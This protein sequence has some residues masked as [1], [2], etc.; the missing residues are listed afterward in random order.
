MGDQQDGEA[1]LP[2]EVGEELEDLRLQ[3]DVERRGRLVGEQQLRPAG[4]RHGDHRPLAL[5]AGEL[6]GVVAEPPSGVGDRHPVEQP[7]RRGPGR[8]PR[9]P[10]AGRAGRMGAQ[11]LG[12][13]EAD[14]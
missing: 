4:E 2:P 14:G 13:L 10:L 1:E 9:Q 7:R 8:A 3:G 5:A 11:D 12:D 6:V